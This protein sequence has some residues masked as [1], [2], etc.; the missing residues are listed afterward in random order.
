MQR[1]TNEYMAACWNRFQRRAKLI[2][3]GKNPDKRR[4]TPRQWRLLV[5]YCRGWNRPSTVDF[6]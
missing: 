4:W 6:A 1:Y 3:V 2:V 5:A